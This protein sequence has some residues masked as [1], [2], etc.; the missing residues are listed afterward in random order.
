M[1]KIA[2]LLIALALLIGVYGWLAYGRWGLRLALA[3]VGIVLYC[4]IF[5]TVLLAQ[6][7]L[8]LAGMIAVIAMLVIIFVSNSISKFLLE[9]GGQ[10]V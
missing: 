9:S 5:S 4:M 6:E 3:C 10:H 7:A 8:A 1:N 2:E